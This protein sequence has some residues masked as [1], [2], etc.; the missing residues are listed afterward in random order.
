M[1]FDKISFG[2]YSVG[3][4]LVGGGDGVTGKSMIF[5]KFTLTHG[6][7]SMLAFKFVLCSVAKTLGIVVSTLGSSRSCIIWVEGFKIVFE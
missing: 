7:F 1:E 3:W 4:S 5:E 2:W 6:L